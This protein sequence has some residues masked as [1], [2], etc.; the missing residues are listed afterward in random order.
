MTTLIAGQR[1]TLDLS[2]I[3][4]PTQTDCWGNLGVV[5]LTID[6][7][8]SKSLNFRPSDLA[9]IVAEVLGKPEPSW[10]L[11][12]Y[13]GNHARTAFKLF[14]TSGLDFV[15][16]REWDWSFVVQV[17][18]SYFVGKGEE[19]KFSAIGKS[20]QK[21]TKIFLAENQALQSAGQV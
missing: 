1:P 4:I 7:E 14:E 13:E 11:L 12:T 6:T 18:P 5:Q 8:L 9:K 2:L 17:N 3:S 10:S 15:I 21:A 16:I 19:A 20:I